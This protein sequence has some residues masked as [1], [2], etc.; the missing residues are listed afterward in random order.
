MV[1]GTDQFKLHGL[2]TLKYLVSFRIRL[3]MSWMIETDNI[4]EKIIAIWLMNIK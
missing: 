3:V 1:A 4:N 2:E